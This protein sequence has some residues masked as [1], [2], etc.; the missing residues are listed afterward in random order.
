MSRLKY[1]KLAREREK[2]GSLLDPEHRLA[3]FK[4]VAAAVAPHPAAVPTPRASEH[5]PYPTNIVGGSPLD[6]VP[7]QAREVASPS[8]STVSTDS[9]PSSQARPIAT[10][11]RHVRSKF[12][13]RT[14]EPAPAA[15]RGSVADVSRASA[16]LPASPAITEL[17]NF[18]TQTLN[19]RLVRGQT[20]TQKS[21]SRGGVKGSSTGSA[22]GGSGGLSVE[23]HGGGGSGAAAAQGP[24]VRVNNFFF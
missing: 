14:R 20:Q 17:M 21:L 16:T 1:Q 10:P 5:Q 18:Q 3:R 13:G 15:L 8:G 2:R 4:R 12:V 11:T 23:G 19:Q 6:P 22:A 24:S 7:P 9:R